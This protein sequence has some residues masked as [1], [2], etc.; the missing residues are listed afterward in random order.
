[1]NLFILTISCIIGGLASLITWIVSPYFLARREYYA[2]S[3]Y[4]L[5]TKKIG[6]C[7]QWFIFVS[8]MASIILEKFLK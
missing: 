8:I 6:W 2:K 7:V 4:G 1:M 5:L 3:Q